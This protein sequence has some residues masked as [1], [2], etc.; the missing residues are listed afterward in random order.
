MAIP[1][2]KLIG[3][4]AKV[5]RGV[6]TDDYIGA[7]NQFA[8][9]DE[10]LGSHKNAIARGKQDPICKIVMGTL[11]VI[12]FEDQLVSLVMK[13]ARAGEWRAVKTEAH[14]NWLKVVAEKNYGYVVEHEGKTYLLP[15][16]YFLVH[17]KEELDD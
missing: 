15:S 10:V 12:E 9:V 5:H 16:A 17:C 8:T 3:N 4:N 13:A 6:Y 2:K 7:L 1:V 14:P 11:G